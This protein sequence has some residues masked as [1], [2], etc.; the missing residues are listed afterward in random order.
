M[1][2]I[3]QYAGAMLAS[4]PAAGS[5]VH[6]WLF[7]TARVLHHYRPAGGIAALLED[8]TQGCG[9]HVSARE[10]QDAVR[11]SEACAY[12]P[13][14]PYRARATSLKRLRPRLI[15]P[16]QKWLGRNACA[17][18]AICADSWGLADLREA[19]SVRTTKSIHVGGENE[20]P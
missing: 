15:A 19:S 17:V 6:N 18:E 14:Q 10:I 8:A 1:K 9:R 5:G 11:N 3:P 4:C 16:P 7:R 12:V 2:P 13:G 20:V